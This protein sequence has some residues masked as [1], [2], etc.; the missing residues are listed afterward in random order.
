MN[1]PH[2]ITHLTPGLNRLIW[3]QL[4]LGKT[5]TG[6]GTHSSIFRGRVIGS[7]RRY[8]MSVQK[9]LK[10]S[11]LGALLM[12]TSIIRYVPGQNC[13]SGTGQKVADFC[14]ADGDENPMLGFWSAGRSPQEYCDWLDPDRYVRGCRMRGTNPLHLVCYEKKIRR[15]I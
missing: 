2:S 12:L 3:I 1:R 8:R 9:C 11:G 10:E 6:R 5:H 13:A 14:L 15:D 4:A 7:P